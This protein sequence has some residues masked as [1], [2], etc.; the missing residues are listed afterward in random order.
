MDAAKQILELDAKAIAKRWNAVTEYNTLA[1]AVA[2]ELIAARERIER[3]EAAMAIVRKAD[4]ELA[5]G[6]EWEYKWGLR[7]SFIAAEAALADPQP[8]VTT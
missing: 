8:Q 1:P 3:L 6:R 5:G 2:R 7:Q 4:K